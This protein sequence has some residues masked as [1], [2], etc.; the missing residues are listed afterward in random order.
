MK[1]ALK[2]LLVLMLLSAG[3]AFGIVPQALQGFCTVGGIRVATSGLLST[4]T[5]LA[6]YPQCT[7]TVY[8]TGTTTPATIYADANSTPLSNPF[9]ANTAASW[10][11]FA[12]TST[13][14]DIVLSG[15]SPIALPSPYTLVDKC[16]GASGGFSQTYF[17]PVA[18]VPSG[19]INGTNATFSL[20]QA[21]ANGYLLLQKNGQVLN[22]GYGY[23][24]S[25]TT[26]NLAA[27]PQVGDT[28]YANY[29]ATTSS[30]T[31][32]YQAVAQAPSG[33]IN[34]SN[35]AFTLTGSPV[36]GT[37]VLQLNGQVLTQG[38]G[39]SITG[40]GI[41]TAAAPQ[42]GDT[43]YANYFAT[44]SS[45]VYAPTSEV[46]AGPED[47]HNTA[48]VLAG[49]PESQ[50][51]I[52]QLNGQILESGLGYTVSGNT[53]ATSTPPALGDVLYAIYFR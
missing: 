19:T 1:T 38:I 20:S 48:F 39:Y 11:F 17:S 7:V 31:L 5:V 51:L 12:A 13:C 9:T 30:S 33:V 23:V 44:T 34:G 6:S 16:P 43:L 3:K 36:T 27:A 46:V 53:I 45:S 25:G 32:S 8:L 47:G 2:S 41:T 24:F 42:V 50:S 52:L 21:P 14:Y 22:N 35:T 4:N 28:L 18:E 40:T 15:G 49:V 26:L 29:F 37:M 10:L